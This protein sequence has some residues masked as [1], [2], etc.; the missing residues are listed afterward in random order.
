MKKLC[1]LVGAAVLLSQSTMSQQKADSTNVSTLDEVVITAN[2]FSQKQSQTGKVVSVINKEQLEKSAGR[3]LGQLLNEQAGITIPG[4]LNAI[5]SPQTLSVRGAG[6]GRTLVL[7][8]GIPAFDPSLINSEFDLNLMSLNDIERIE[9][10]RGAQST[11]YGSDAMGGVVNI[12]TTKTDVQKPF[13]VK[14]TASY[15]NLNTFR[16][17]VQ[18]FGKSGKL[19]YNAKYARLSTDGFSAAH[20]EQ[21]TGNFDDDGYNGQN[22]G[23]SVQ[24]QVNEAFQLRSFVQRNLYKADVDGGVFTDDKDFTIDNK[25]TMA[26]AGFGFK[27]KNISITGNYQYSDIGRFYLND[28]ADVSGFA[29]YVTD[30]YFGRN[31]FAELYGTIQVGNG[32]SLLLGTD[33]R[34]NSMNS[35]YYSLSG[36]G[37]FETAFSD[38]SV[39]Q[40]AVYGSVIYNHQRLNVE[41]GSRINKHEQ[42]GTNA[43]YTFNPSYQVSK[44]WRVFGS[45][46]SAFKAPSLYQLYSSFGNKDLQAETATT[47]EAGVQHSIKGLAN[48]VVY[49]HRD[50]KNGIDFDNIQFTYFNFNRQ[51][52]NGIEFESS[53]RTLK[54]FSLTAN[55]T[56]LLGQE[57][58]QSRISTK[59]TTYHYLLR[60]PKHNLNIT[61]GYNLSEKVEFSLTGK[62]V[63]ERYD[64]G[65]YQVADVKLDPYFLLNAHVSYTINATF[66]IFADAQNLLNNKFF[67]I[68]GYNAIPFLL[69]AGVSV[70]L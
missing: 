52:V 21:G 2:R 37:P 47:Y 46:A 28:S 13:N 66:R 25:N 11:L 19:S 70:Q 33:Y 17:N 67:D 35:Q 44:N 9:I 69:N 20:D 34:F 65:G 6:P 26:G 31:Q 54:G 7:I 42:Y 55:Y 27:K 18:L 60:R 38:T 4:A 8:D 62:Y 53:F 15:G 30:N 63:S 56:L 57:S 41:L 45:I 50:I 39:S 68:S 49:F 29:K 5:G 51:T 48:R 23:A 12:I 32:W 14:A 36:F 16:G 1:V 40:V 59:D 43:T 64:A 24:Y 58:M 3:T 10:A 61:A 22:F